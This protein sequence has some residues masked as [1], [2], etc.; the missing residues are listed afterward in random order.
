MLNVRAEV[1]EMRGVR[2]VDEVT[3]SDFVNLGRD[4]DRT[5]QSRHC[6]IF[7]IATGALCLHRSI[8][9]NPIT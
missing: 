2:V 3:V 6:C 4:D 9:D 7:H 8:L 1:D 5:R